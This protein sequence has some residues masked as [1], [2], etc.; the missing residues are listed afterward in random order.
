MKHLKTI[1]LCAVLAC[2][3]V[4]CAT[5]IAYAGDADPQTV[6]V[7]SKLTD[8]EGTTK[9]LT[10]GGKTY[11]VTI[12]KDGFAKPQDAFDA[13]AVNGTVVLDEG[14]YSEAVEIRKDVNVKGPKAGIDPNVRGQ[15]ATDDWTRST[16]R[17]TGEAILKTSWHVGVVANKAVFDCNNVTF[18][19]LM[20]SAGGM[21]RS[22]YGEEGHI[23]I[24]YKNILVA[25]YGTGANG[26]FYFV[27]YYPNK[28]T[29]LYRRDIT[30]ENIRF[31]GIKT[32]G[33]N[34]CADT[35]NAKGIYFDSESTGKF[36]AHWCVSDSKKYNDEIVINVEDSMFRNKT[37][38]VMNFNFS[39]NSG[40]YKFNAG[41]ETRKKVTVTVKNNVFANND[42]GIAT[43]NNIIVPQVYSENVYFN[44]TDNIFYMEN[45]ASD[46]FIA[47]HGATAAL[48]LGEKFKISDNR[49]IGIPTALNISK[50]TTAFDLS[51][52]Y[53]EDS[54]KVP[55]KP[56]VVGPDKTEWW[57]MD[58]DMKTT[59]KAAGQVYDAVLDCGTV[60][61]EKLTMTDTVTT[62]SYTFKIKTSNFNKL[63]VYGDKDLKETLSSTV[64]LH[65]K[66]N[67]FYVKLSSNDGSVSKVY[68]ATIKTNNPDTL[69]LRLGRDARFFGRTYSENGTYF[70]NWS[71]SGF[72]FKFKGSG[73][74]AT[75]VSTAP[76]GSNNAFIKIFVDGVE[77]PD[78]ELKNKINEVTL[79]SG[80]DKDKE[81]TIM[82]L[83][84][85]NGR[86]SSA[87]VS[88]IKLT[89]GTILEAPKAKTK[90]I[91]F[92]GDSITVG[93]ATLGKN[94]DTWSTSTEDVS[95][96]YIRMIA[97]AFNAD[98]MVT[99]ISGRGVVRNTGGDTDKLMP[100]IYK[101]LDIYNN[102]GVDYDFERQPDVIVI[103][104]GT[105]DA[106]GSNPNLTAAEFE[107]GLKA[108][109]IDVRAKNPKAEIIYA[110]GFM[111]TKFKSSMEKVVKELNDA[112]DKNISFMALKTCTVK[113][114]CIGHPTAAAYVSR[115]E[116]IIEQI[117]KVTGW[118][119][120]G[121]EEPT[122]TTSQPTTE[123][124]TSEPGS[125]TKAPDTNKEPEPTS[126]NEPSTEKTSEQNKGCK[127]TVV[128]AVAMVAVSCAAAVALKKKED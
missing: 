104:L 60:D 118:Q 11:N 22:N 105:N 107:A 33:C 40:G 50:S 95:K 78:V 57:Y 79:A 82:V 25:E 8:A 124:N 87:G 75:I 56:V 9:E 64:I 54:D 37:N 71:A 110:Y 18:D 83:K 49:F 106:S 31:E 128:S 127:S 76:G 28:T 108:F 24:E 30:M 16:E 85:T 45:K 15:K 72:E 63:E 81:H 90:L 17:G 52:N 101:Y 7:S 41:I 86:S 29:N 113:E 19:G 65:A 66:E 117:S 69:T 23:K 115:G 96:T 89:D 123:T 111:T 34:P 43:N 48:P 58:Y 67:V 42:T 3:M 92:I 6:V 70:F 26:P 38:Q 125:D 122:E 97:E 109:L 10:I 55:G 27:S 44:I 39:E 91:E 73:A 61:N 36:F 59:S 84:R 116:A 62:S 80:L 94:G 98:Y 120:G 103:N 21:F 32:P 47:I 99:A 74:K 88:D 5:L 93:Y 121:S 119:K 53:F 100:E 4:L 20:V 1:L 2:A 126:T 46:N 12:G 114:K 102:P 112:G 35:F 51:G 77:Q 14:V 68:V 13:V